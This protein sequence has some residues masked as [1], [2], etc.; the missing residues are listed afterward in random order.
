MVGFLKNNWFKLG[1]LL[2]GLIWVVSLFGSGS[3][4]NNSNIEAPATAPQN[5]YQQG[6]LEEI[7][8][9]KPTIPQN[10][11][12][13]APQPQNNLNYTCSYNAYNCS[14]FSTHA[15]AQ[16]VYDSCGGVLNDVHNLDRDKDGLACESLP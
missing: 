6:Q 1:L 9:N 4:S 3:G 2:I 12:F 16:Q 15:E 8:K 10:N 14:N 11:N 5:S 7:F 13:Q